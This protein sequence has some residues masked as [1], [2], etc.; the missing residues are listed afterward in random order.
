MIARFATAISSGTFITLALFYVMNVLIVIQP[1][2]AS[3]PPPVFAADWIQQS[4]PDDP[5]IV[6]QPPVERPDFVHPPIPD[7]ANPDAGESTLHIVR[8]TPPTPASRPAGLTGMSPDGPLVAMIRVSP[9]YPT[10]AAQRELE[11]FVK[12]QFDVLADGSVANVRV[13][14]SSHRVFEANAVRAANGFRYKPHVADGV[15]QVTTGIRY[16]FT[17]RMDDE[18]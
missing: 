14:A 1:G 4:P 9:V 15:P 13:I 3:E 17:F 5:P 2:A 10:M 6:E 7:L 11:G 12:V 8:S 16:L 18:N